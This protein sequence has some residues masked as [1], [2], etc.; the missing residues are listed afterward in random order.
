MKRRTVFKHLAAATAA[1]WI[2]PGCISD[3]KK[4]SLALNHLQVTG[5]E[6]ELLGDIADVMIPVTDTP[7]ARTVQAHLFTL[8]MVDDCLSKAEQEKFLKGMRG[9]PAELKSLTGKAFSSASSDERLEML[10]T[11]EGRRVALSEEVRTFYDT[12]RN[13]ILQGY[14]SSQHFMTDIK[15]YQLVPGPHYRGCV[16]VEA[17][18]LS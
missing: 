13:Y 8:V 6:E 14:T 2:L 5:E 18:T 10:T 4:V 16:K 7:G 9:F 3:P 1:A 11:L 12:T 17:Q 15:P